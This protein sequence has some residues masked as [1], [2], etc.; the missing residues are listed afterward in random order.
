MAGRAG[1]ARPACH[2][3][4]GLIRCGEPSEAGVCGRSFHVGGSH[5]KYMFCPGHAQGTCGCY[6]TLPRRL[7][8]ELV[9][10]EIAARVLNNETWLQA[11]YR[12]TQA[13]WRRMR[14]T[15]PDELRD[16]EVALAEVTRKIG[17]LVDQV[18]GTDQPDPDLAK[19]LSERRAERREL[20]ARLTAARRT[21]A[22]QPVEPTLEWVRERVAQLGATLAEA[23]PAAAYALRDLLDGPI[24]VREIRRPGR[25]RHYLQGVLRIRL[26]TAAAALGVPLGKAT[27]GDEGPCEELTID[28][29]RED[30]RDALSERAK[31]LWDCARHHK[32]IAAELGC[33]PQYVTKLLKH[34]SQ[35]HATPLP[36]GRSRRSD[37]PPRPE[38]LPLYQRIAGTVMQLYATDMELG[39]IAARLG[40]DR[41]TVTAAV[42]YWHESRGL[43]VPDGRT[44]RKSLPRSTQIPQ[45]LPQ[46]EVRPSDGKE[47]SSAA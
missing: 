45:D 36:D 38:A 8:E 31:E 22:E 44:R 15:L 32:V 37:L 20:E 46:D 9:L 19:R 16:V 17:R 5:G 12:A 24:I 40:H 39:D 25:R 26:A 23:V 1:A 14:Q 47:D 34:W 13:A 4:S 3:L 27:A 21:A 28:F 43:P 6:T 29:R 11:I 33:S 35:R 41:N 30:P 10:R 42:R 7:A 2:L 18:E